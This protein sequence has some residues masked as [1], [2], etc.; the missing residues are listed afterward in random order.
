MPPKPTAPWKESHDF[1][2]AIF[3]AEKLLDEPWSDPDDDARTVARQFNRMLERNDILQKQLNDVL[4]HLFDVHHCNC[5]L[6]CKK[7]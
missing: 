7:K 6:I 3:A 5:D 4:E 1:K 2:Q